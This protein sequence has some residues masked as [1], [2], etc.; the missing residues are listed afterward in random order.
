MN[1]LK[2]GAILAGGFLNRVPGI[3]SKQ[4]YNKSCRTIGLLLKLLVA[5]SVF[6]C[7]NSCLGPVGYT[8]LVNYGANM[9]R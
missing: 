8:K 9:V 5:Q 7:N 2:R 6:D 3:Q 1:S 4:E